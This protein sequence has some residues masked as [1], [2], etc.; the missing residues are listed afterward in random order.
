M[1]AAILYSCE[2]CGDIE[3]IAVKLLQLE[4]KALK[5]CL[6][7]K[8][9]N[10]KDIIYCELNIPDVKATIIHK[11][12]NFITKIKKFADREAMVSY[13]SNLQLTEHYGILLL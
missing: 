11:Q 2:A 12:Y 7:V 8:S 4:R 6:G 3:V 5:R 10:T 9:G 1:L 13:Y